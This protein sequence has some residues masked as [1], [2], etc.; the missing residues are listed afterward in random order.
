M[1]VCYKGLTGK[2]NLEKAEIWLLKAAVLY[3]H[4]KD[5][6]VNSCNELVD[7]YKQLGRTERA[8]EWG[9]RAGGKS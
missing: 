8:T 6:Y 9:R 2:G 5:I 7:V 3:R 1:G 4:H